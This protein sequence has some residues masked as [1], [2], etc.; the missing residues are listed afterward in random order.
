[1]KTFKWV[2]ILFGALF[3]HDVL[4][5]TTASGIIQFT[6]KVYAP[7]SAAM[8]LSTSNASRSLNEAQ[9][10]ALRNAQRMLPCEV[11]DYFATYAAKDAKFVS[12]SYN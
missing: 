1:M 10:Y 4:A 3:A 8:A 5:A 9:T 11:L 7:A 2:A 12:V 6:G